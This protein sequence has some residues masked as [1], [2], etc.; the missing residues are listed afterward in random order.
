VRAKTSEDIMKLAVIG[1]G[2][3]GQKHLE[4]VRANAGAM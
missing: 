4:I 3:I 1:A 2:L